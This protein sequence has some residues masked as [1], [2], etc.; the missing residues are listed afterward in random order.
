MLRRRGLLEVVC[1]ALAG[2]LSDL[3]D[4]PSQTDSASPTG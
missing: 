1:K 4:G 2:D 3:S